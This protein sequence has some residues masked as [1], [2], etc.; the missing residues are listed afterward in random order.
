MEWSGCGLFK[1]RKQ[2]LFQFTKK[3]HET[4]SITGPEDEMRTQNLPNMQWEWQPL[5][6]DIWYVQECRINLNFVIYFISLYNI[7]NWLWNYVFC[8]YFLKFSLYGAIMEQ[9]GNYVKLQICCSLQGHV[10]CH[11][12]T[13]LL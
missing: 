4:I 7:R 9:L 13:D 11:H 2:N 3:N 1:M 5:L 8:S 12:T 10:V 6:L